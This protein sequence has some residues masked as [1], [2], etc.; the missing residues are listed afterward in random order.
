MKSGGSSRR[1]QL[2]AWIFLAVLACFFV[3]ANVTAETGVY[4][5][6]VSILPDGKFL[7]AFAK[8]IA[9]AKKS[10]YIAIYMFK[11]YDNEKN[12]AGLILASLRNAAERG[13]DVHV[14]LD[15]SDDGD[16]VEKENRETGA[17]LAKAGI[18]VTY[19]DPK[20]RLHSK[21]AVIDGQ[22]TYI[23]SHNYTNSALFHNK[24]VTVRIVSPEAAND[25]LGHI[26]SIK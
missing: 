19:D 15:S 22:I 9:A 10:I 12:G 14:V 25:A 8:D 20:V 17:G 18:K 24:E 4:R 2:K 13:V 23:G 6:D 1:L 11:S 21:C 26:Q 5:A 3:Y 7:P 16:F